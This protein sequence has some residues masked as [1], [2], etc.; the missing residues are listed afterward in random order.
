MSLDYL[1]GAIPR[2]NTE[3]LIGYVCY[4]FRRVPTVASPRDLEILNGV[5]TVS[6]T[7][8]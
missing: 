1:K 6:I 7:V 4:P 8:A 2:G 5:A 3:P